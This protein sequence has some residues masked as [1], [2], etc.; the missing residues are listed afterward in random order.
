MSIYSIFYLSSTIS[1]ICPSI[2]LY[3]LSFSPSLLSLYLFFYLHL[4]YS[5]S[6]T[7]YIYH[8]S[9]HPLLSLSP[10]SLLLSLFLP[11]LPPGSESHKPTSIPGLTSRTHARAFLFGLVGS[12]FLRVRGPCRT[13]GE[14]D[15]P[16]EEQG[17]PSEGQRLPWAGSQA[18]DLTSPRVPQET[19]VVLTHVHR[20][21]RGNRRG[22]CVG[23]ARV[24]ETGCK[25]HA[26][27]LV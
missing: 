19:E 6:L 14:S 12:R 3:L 9:V 11:R 25:H 24:S 18:S 26:E 8:P 4:L 7:H 23:I 1:T 20:D 27:T 13:P 22:G 2:S 16:V 17:H 21:I 5:L 15:V 10:P